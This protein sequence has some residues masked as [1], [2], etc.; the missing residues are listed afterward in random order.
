MIDARYLLYRLTGEQL[1]R[2]R[3]TIEV[4]VRE[5]MSALHMLGVVVLNRNSEDAGQH[6]I[7]DW[8]KATVELTGLGRYAIRRVKGMAQPGDPMLRTWITLLEVSDPS[9]WREIITP[10]NYTLDRVLR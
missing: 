9:V 10:A 1:D 6:G 2:V 3:H 7:T 4:D 5:A 8:S